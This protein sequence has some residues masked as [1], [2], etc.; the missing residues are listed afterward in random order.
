[1]SIFQPYAFDPRG[2]GVYYPIRQAT[3]RKKEGN[4]NPIM[5]ANLWRKQKRKPNVYASA[6]TSRYN[7]AEVA[8]SNF[9]QYGSGKKYTPAKQIRIGKIRP[10]DIKYDTLGKGSGLPMRLYV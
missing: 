9:S 8:P 10:G 3:I 7:I 6:I 2:A 1:M 4:F 5:S